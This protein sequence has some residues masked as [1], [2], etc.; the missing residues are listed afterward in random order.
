MIDLGVGIKDIELIV[1]RALKGPEKVRAPRIEELQSEIAQLKV[2]K[3]RLEKLVDGC[4]KNG[5]V[6]L[7]NVSSRSVSS[8]TALPLKLK[9]SSE[10]LSTETDEKIA[11]LTEALELA[12]VEIRFFHVSQFSCLHVLFR[13]RMW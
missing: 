2:D 6:G 8:F 10:S 7:G 1:D 9:Q 13:Q 5:G 4:K 11:S 12:L 3:T